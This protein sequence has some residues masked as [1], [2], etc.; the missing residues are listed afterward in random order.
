MRGGQRVYWR[1]RHA[2]RRL[3]RHVLGAGASDV[4]MAHVAFESANVGNL[5]SHHMPPLA[6]A[7]SARGLQLQDEV[8][9]REVQKHLCDAAGVSVPP[10]PQFPLRLGLRVPQ[11]TKRFRKVRVHFVLQVDHATVRMR[12]RELCRVERHARQT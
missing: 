6:A 12:N 9:F 2:R 3:L 4:G 5:Q 10:A 8:R 7:E 11:P 1:H